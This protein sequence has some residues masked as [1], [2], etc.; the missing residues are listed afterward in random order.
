MAIKNKISVPSFHLH[1]RTLD[2]LSFNFNLKRRILDA[3]I[4]VVH[5]QGDRGFIFAL[6]KKK[7]L[8]V[9]AHTSMKIGLRALSKSRYHPSPY[10]RVL[11]EKCAFKKADKIIVVSESLGNSIR[12]D[13]NIKEEKIVYIPNAVDVEKFNPEVNPDIIRKKFNINGPLLLCVARL[14]NGRFVEKLIPTIHEVKKEIP[15]IK[16]MLVGDGPAR[17][18][19][20]ELLQRH[21]LEKNIILAGA[22]GDEELP[23]F[24]AAADLCISPMVYSPAKKEFNVLEALACGKLLIY[25]NRL[26][27]KDGEE[28]ITK[29]NPISVNNDQDFASSIIELLQNERK[30]KKLGSMGREAIVNG[31]SWAQVAKETIK[32][33]NSVI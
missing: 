18:S 25:V 30:I 11:T 21:G 15:G 4:N 14:E 5:S 2:F 7:P 8:I 32:V 6:N 10:L 17:R 27:H 24:Y 31:Y 33:Y 1:D 22:R 16:L 12:N 9:T 29:E 13:Y 19:F 26:G 23:F 28:I 20:E 3:D